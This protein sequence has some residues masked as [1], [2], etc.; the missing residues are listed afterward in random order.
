MFY[1]TAVENE[2]FNPQE[3]YI[4]EDKGFT[5]AGASAIWQGEEVK[6]DTSWFES[7]KPT[8]HQRN[9]FYVFKYGGSGE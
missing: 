7:S 1:S 2:C 8:C 6:R 9:N 4:C 3:A 5:R